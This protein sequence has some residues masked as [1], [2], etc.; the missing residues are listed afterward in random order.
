MILSLLF[1]AGQLNVQGVRPL[2]LTSYLADSAVT[3]AILADNRAVLRQAASTTHGEQVVTLEIEGNVQP[4]ILRC[5]VHSVRGNPLESFW[6]DEENKWQVLSCNGQRPRASSVKVFAA[7]GSCFAVSEGLLQSLFGKDAKAI[8]QYARKVDFRSLDLRHNIA[9]AASGPKQVD[10]W[11]KGRRYHVT[12]QLSD[13]IENV[14]ICDDNCFII[15]LSSGKYQTVQAP[16]PNTGHCASTWYASDLSA[17]DVLV[18]AL[19]NGLLVSSLYSVRLLSNSG[20]DKQ[21]FESDSGIVTSTFDGNLLL[22]SER[23]GKVSI[24]SV[25]PATRAKL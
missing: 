11:Q 12:V 18:G 3:S 2:L 15:L 5:S 24:I 20:Q 4:S 22:I 8:L 23:S 17:E 1:L 10:I 21:L 16:F 25:G 13:D 9:V 14:R 7:E 19:P 6:L